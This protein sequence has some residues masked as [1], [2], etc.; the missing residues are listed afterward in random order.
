MSTQRLSFLPAAWAVPGL[1]LL[2]ASLASGAGLT[3]RP[4]WPV[5]RKLAAGGSETFIAELTAGRP[6]LLTAEQIGLDVILEAAGPDGSRVAVDAPFDRSGVESLLIKPESSGSFQIEVKAREPGSP[7][8]RFRLRLEE[9][10]DGTPAA[11]LAAEEG[12]T[13]AG[14]LYREGSKESRREALTAYREAAERWRSL[15][16]VRGEAR[17]LYAAAVMARL[18]QE[19]Q[20]ALELANQALVLWQA[21]GEPLREAATWNEIGLDHWLLGEGEKARPAFER[22][23]ALQQAAEDV[24]GEAASLSNLCL[25]DLSRGELRSGLACYE[26]ALPLLREAQA[27]ELEGGALTSAGRAWD[28]LGEPDRS[29]ELYGRALESARAA[30]SRLSEAQTLNNLAVLHQ[31]LGDAQ[32]ALALLARALSIFRELGD[33]RWQA[34]VLNN[35]GFVYHEA[36]DRERALAQYGQALALWREVGDRAGE[37]AALSNLARAQTLLGDPRAALDLYGQALELRRAT[38]DR[39]GEGIVLTGLA[40]AQ[41]A[42][43]DAAAALAGCGKSVELLRSAGDLAGQTDAERTCA[44]ALLML[45]EAEKARQAFTRALEISRSAR[46]KVAEAQALFGLARAERRLGQAA[47]AREH[48]AAAI[49]VSE[50]LRIRIGDPDLRASFSALKHQAY[51]LRIDLLME[52]HR[53]DPAAGYDREALATVERSRARTLVELLEEGGIDLR[54]GADPGLLD[55]RDSLLR[56]LSAKAARALR[57]TAPKAEAEALES[58]R[59]ELLRELDLVEAEIRDRSPAFADLTRPRALS[60]VEIQALLDPGTLL[61]AYSLG[62]SRSFLWAVTLSSTESFELPGRAALEDAAR[63]FHVLLSALD[64]AD[65]YGQS[66]AAAELSRLLLG[67]VAGRLGERPRVAILADGAL[68][69]VPFAALPLPGTGEASPLLERH[70]VVQVPSATAVAAQ[71]RILARRR[72]APRWLAVVA[73]PVF[74]PG[75]PR[76]TGE[77]L[78]AAPAAGVRGEVPF[79]RLL[80]SRREAEVIAAL[81]PPGKALTALDFEASRDR[82]LGDQLAGFRVVHFATHGVFDAAR[83][84][85][86]GLVLSAVDRR[87]RPREGFL[88]LRDVYTQRLDADLVVLSGCRTALGKEVRGEGLLGLTRGF[89]Y[90]GALRVVASLWRADDRATAELMTRFYRALWVDRLLPAA[91]LRSAQLSIRQE[92]RWRDPFFWA[93][94]VIEGVW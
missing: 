4:G 48:A 85:L 41:T 84:A 70:E 62:E 35:I 11:R 2:A 89:Q 82:V 67:P 81:A 25:L 66:L 31:E 87:G 86:S 80:A 88:H 28:V 14:R 8:G 18:V 57:G 58:E 37:A 46:H 9:L 10:P 33:R 54:A 26:R 72:P 36:G 63:R 93:G 91:A 73:D 21:A 43:G 15:G 76:V 45:G 61:L 40:R 24:Y 90:A 78:A 6:V 17:A 56:R 51:E 27:P 44:E 13:R 30:G 69:Y 52:A 53:A 79:E 49:E 83:P 68:H 55:R 22:A 65:R 5:E 42:L 39:R 1:A 34:R 47:E 64:P 94:W 74:D 50:A 60:A 71:R 59:Q 77:K 92:R 19:T 12:L 7:P 20:P 3:L 38:G 75:D 23:R 29:L 16:E 32:E